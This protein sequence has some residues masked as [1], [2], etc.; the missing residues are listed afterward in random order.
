MNAPIEV[1]LFLFALIMGVALVDKEATIKTRLVVMWCVGAFL[2]G[3][4][5][6]GWTP[7]FRITDAGTG[8]RL[9]WMAADSDLSGGTPTR[10]EAASAP[11]PST[12]E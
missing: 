6:A 2:L 1:L 8:E 9:G 12:P 5:V 4:A 3:Y 7:N 10:P 11:R